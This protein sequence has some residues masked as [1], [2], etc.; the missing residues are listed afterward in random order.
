MRFSYLKWK[1]LWLF[2]FGVAVASSFCMKWLEN[3]FVL[4]NDRFNIIGL[5]LFYPKDKLQSVLTDL[6]TFA[7]IKKILQY[8][9]WFDFVFMAGIYPGIASLCMMA[10]LKI[11]SHTWKKI[12]LLLAI[13]QVAAWACDIYENLQ[14]LRWIDN[15][16]IGTEVGIYHIIVSIKWALALSAALTGGSILLLHLNKKLPG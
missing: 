8:Q 4:N 9:L 2:C 14:L 12:L 6:Q 13:L 10:R 16:M 15:P 7:G 11:I 5:E 3:D 1:Q